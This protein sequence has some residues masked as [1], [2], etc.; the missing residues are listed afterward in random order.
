MTKNKI[1]YFSKKILRKRSR[2]LE[3]LSALEKDLEGLQD[4]QPKDWAE[5]INDV[6]DRETIMQKIEAEKENLR[7]VNESLQKMIE[8][9]YGQCT[10]CEAPIP[11]ARL[12][13]LPLAR[14]CI[15][16][17]V[18]KEHCARQAC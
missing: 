4:N 14:L 17:Q 15:R 16:C 8:G 9:S 10:S 2:I 1:D 18:V 11:E 5:V 6:M 13:A 12:R 7:S 3:K